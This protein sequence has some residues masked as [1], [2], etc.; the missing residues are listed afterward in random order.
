MFYSKTIYSKKNTFTFA[1]WNRA[2]QVLN[3]LVQSSE[4]LC[5]RRPRPSTKAVVCRNRNIVRQLQH[6][7]QQAHKVIISIVTIVIQPPLRPPKKARDRPHPTCQNG[8]DHI[9]TFSIKNSKVTLKLCFM[10]LTA[11]NVPSDHL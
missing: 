8:P 5:V 11:N 3:F 10:S 2:L 9:F 7:P 6:T 1:S 4:T